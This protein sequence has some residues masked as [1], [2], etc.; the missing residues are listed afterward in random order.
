[1]SPDPHNEPLM[2]PQDIKL[3]Q[4]RPMTLKWGL[5]GWEEGGNPDPLLLMFLETPAVVFI[6]DGAPGIDVDDGHRARDEQHECELH[7][8]ADLH[9]HDGGD[10]RQHSNVVVIL[11]VLR[12]AILHLHPC[13]AVGSRVVL[14][15]AKLET[16]TA[17]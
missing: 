8:V 5:G 1:M 10:E 2:N 11:R 6:K 16:R 14:E 7:H 13:S 4:R 9:Q 17:G 15:A 3:S 12:A